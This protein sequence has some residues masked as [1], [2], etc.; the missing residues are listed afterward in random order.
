M[1]NSGSSGSANSI[2]ASAPFSSRWCT[3]ASRARCDGEILNDVS[4]M[5][6][7]PKMLSS[8]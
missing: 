7:G 8:K 1:R 2:G 6:S 5:P 3:V 4:F